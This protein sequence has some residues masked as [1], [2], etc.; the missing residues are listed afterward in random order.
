MH[1]NQN[2]FSSLLVNYFGIMTIQLAQL[3]KDLKLQRKQILFSFPHWLI[4]CHC[5]Q[6]G[7]IDN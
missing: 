2:L 7:L 3:C 6:V 5:I 1:S 4:T